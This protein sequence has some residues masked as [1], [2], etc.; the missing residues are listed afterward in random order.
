MAGSAQPLPLSRSEVRFADSHS[1]RCKRLTA[2]DNGTPA[3]RPVRK[4]AGLMETAGLPKKALPAVAGHLFLMR[5]HEEDGDDVGG[6][7][8]PGCLQ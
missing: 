1:P 4:A 2:S 3:A 6:G 8:W 7:A 5:K